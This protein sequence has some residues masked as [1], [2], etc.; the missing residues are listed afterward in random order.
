MHKI[1]SE[2]IVLTRPPAGMP[3]GIRGFQPR[4]AAGMPP[5]GMPAGMRGVPSAR[6]IHVPT[7]AGAAG[8]AGQV[9]QINMPGQPPTNVPMQSLQASRI[10]YTNSLTV[11][12]VTSRVLKKKQNLCYM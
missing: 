2:Q 11:L 7:V 6:P 10:L 1:K 9:V 3:A 5:P 8:P 12:I 4:T